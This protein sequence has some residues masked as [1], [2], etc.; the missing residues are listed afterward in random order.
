L[1]CGVC[2]DCFGEEGGYVGG[3]VV[4]ALEGEAGFVG[5]FVAD[6]G[7]GGFGDEEG[8]ENEEATPDETD[9]DY[10]FVTCVCG[11]STREFATIEPI[12]EPRYCDQSANTS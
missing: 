10:N 3:F 7:N 4:E 6:E 2:E 1:F 8:E 11:I 5:L 9:E 12:R